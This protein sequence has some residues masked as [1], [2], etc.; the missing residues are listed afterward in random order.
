MQIR[1]SLPIPA[2]HPNQAGG[3]IAV[4]LPFAVALALA[5]WRQKRWIVVGTAVILTGVM[6]VGLLLTSSRAA[7]LALA[8]A[9]LIGLLWPLSQRL[10]RIMPWPPQRIF[11]LFLALF[12]LAGWGLSWV[13]AGGPLALVGHLPGADSSASRLELYRQTVDLIADFPFTGG[14]LASFPGLYSQYIAVTPFFLFDYS[15]NLWLDVAVEQGIAGGLVL[16]LLY[17][18]SVG[19][20]WR[21][22]TAVPLPER[23]HEDYLVWA[24]AVSLLVLILHG[25]VDDAIYGGLGTPLLFLLPGMIVFLAPAS[26]TDHFARPT[27]I[28]AAHNRRIAGGVLLLLVLVGGLVN[29]RQV[30]AEWYANWGAV[31]MARTELADWPTGRWDDGRNLAALTP[32]QAQFQ[33]AVALDET[34][35]T[36]QYRLGLIAMLGRDYATAV[37]HLEISHEQNPDHRG[38]VKS[39]GYSYVWSGDLVQGAVLLTAISEAGREMAVYSWWW[40][41][42]GEADLAQRAAEMAA[43]L[44]DA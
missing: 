14:G 37:T 7:W 40:Q 38:I 32:A 34:N 13:I 33:R 10:A 5:G 21:V 39:L 28:L 41:E 26:E 17:A 23:S 35:V 19:L 36:A 8:A 16:I 29:R 30:A 25:L 22:V 6:A 42:Q 44:N 18:G 15:H 3:L 4:L 20:L 2:I 31:L 27:S 9:L 12:L 24:T 11:L 43:V 1:P